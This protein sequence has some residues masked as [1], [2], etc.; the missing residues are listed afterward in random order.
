MAVVKMNLPKCD[1]CGEVWLPDRR[2]PDGTENP[3]RE[4]PE[5]CKRCGKC[6]TPTWNKGNRNTR[7]QIRLQH[8]TGQSSIRTAED[9]LRKSEPVQDGAG[10][11][12][13]YGILEN[14]F[15]AL[16]GGEAFLKAERAAWGPDPWEKIAL[17]DEA[18][19]ERTK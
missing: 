7:G 1:A 6:K 15:R 17:E 12:T 10:L 16:G 8:S 19:S 18:R 2:L 13:L 5:L 11:Q 3:A 4:N 14:E 9:K